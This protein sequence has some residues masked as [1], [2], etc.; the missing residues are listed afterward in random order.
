[1]GQQSWYVFP[2]NLREFFQKVK[3]CFLR[4]KNRQSSIGSTEASFYPKI[5]I[6]SLNNNFGVVLNVS[7]QKKALCMQFGA[8]RSCEYP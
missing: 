2:S 6:V 4:N 7:T 3:C 1:M 5:L 8:L